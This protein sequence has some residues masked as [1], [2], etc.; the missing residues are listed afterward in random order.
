MGGVNNLSVK[1]LSGTI[2][3]VFNDVPN[4][5]EVLNDNITWANLLLSKQQTKIIYC[6]LIG[7]HFDMYNKY[8]TDFKHQQVVVDE[9]VVLFN[10]TL[11]LINMQ[12]E[13]VTPWLQDTIHFLTKGKRIH[14]YSKLRDGI[15]P[16]SET[17]DTWARL[18][19]KWA[20]TNLA[21]AA[22]RHWELHD[23]GAY[24]WLVYWHYMLDTVLVLT[25]ST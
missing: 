22:G 15:H 8:S 2:S 23:V 5:V 17:A 24:V 20:L 19:A 9:G 21:K 16:T 14:R 4:M 12:S 3:P 1:H 11:N 7:L 25:L 18:L 6:Q 10:Q 13:V